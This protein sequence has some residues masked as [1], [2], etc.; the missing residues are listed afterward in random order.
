MDE[1]DK[2][3]KIPEGE[4]NTTPNPNVGL[5]SKEEEDIVKEAKMVAATQKET[6][7]LKAA[8]LEKEEK[9]LAR[10]EALNSL[11]GGSAAGQPSEKKEETNAD[12]AE[13]IASGN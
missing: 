2:K 7:E 12:Y 8:N 4:E 3:E 6:E 10:K 11:G 1:K 5:P 9:L 13:R